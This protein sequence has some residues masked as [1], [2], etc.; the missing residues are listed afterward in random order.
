MQNTNNTNIIAQAL[1]IN[2]TD[3]IKLLAM[4]TKSATGFDLYNFGMP[5]VEADITTEL[6]NIAYNEVV[7]LLSSDSKELDN[8]PQADRNRAHQQNEQC[9]TGT[10]AHPMSD[11]DRLDLAL[12]AG[13][14]A[15]TWAE[16]LSRMK[17]EKLAW[18]KDGFTTKNWEAVD[19]K[20]EGIVEICA[21]DGKE[22]QD[23]IASGDNRIHLVEHHVRGKLRN[24]GD[25]LDAQFERTDAEKAPKWRKRLAMA[26]RLAGNS[27]RGHEG[28]AIDTVKSQFFTWA[29]E[30]P[31][32]GAEKTRLETAVE[33]V[34]NRKFWYEVKNK[35]NNLAIFE[36]Y[37]AKNYTLLCYSPELKAAQLEFVESQEAYDIAVQLI[38][39]RREAIQNNEPVNARNYQNKC[40][41]LY[42][43]LAP[44]IQTMI[45]ES[46]DKMLLDD[47]L[48]V[49]E[50][51]RILAREEKQIAT[52]GVRL[53]I[54][55]LEVQNELRR[56]EHAQLMEAHAKKMQALNDLLNPPKK[57]KAPTKTTKAKAKTTKARAKKATPL[58]VAA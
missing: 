7:F 28:V 40:D 22:L 47:L 11:E 54:K 55:T 24:F 37:Q 52:I 12:G 57:E 50:S 6:L 2:F 43:H 41:A 44:S 58:T 5:K 33:R 13:H 49:E 29:N 56:R 35:V 34:A 53:E 45:S 27:I 30:Y 18:I 4:P 32:A 36:K 31:F 9:D 38:E 42:K 25:Y 20:D 39:Q 17:G 10:K 23:L 8:T 15:Y 21:K 48:Q 19:P 1:A 3:G 16:H 26:K 51:K 46:D 14:M